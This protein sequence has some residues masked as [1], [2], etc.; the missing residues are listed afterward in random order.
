M[1][2]S[3]GGVLISVVAST[4]GCSYTTWMGMIVIPVEAIDKL[5]EINF[6]SYDDSIISREHY[7]RHGQQ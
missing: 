6:G 1:S 4:S 7:S 3:T 2:D 5:H